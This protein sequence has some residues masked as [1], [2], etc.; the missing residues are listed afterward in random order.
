MHE[1][2]EEIARLRRIV[3]Y[4]D[5]T[6]EERSR[7]GAIQVR[8]DE[9]DRLREIEKTAREYR[10]IEEQIWNDVG[11]LAGDDL[12]NLSIT[13]ERLDRLLQRG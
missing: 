3:G 10:N 11:D 8:L 6:D 2:D 12:D 1:K 4:T 7:F 5:A 13:R 9:W